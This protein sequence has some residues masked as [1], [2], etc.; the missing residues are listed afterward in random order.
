MLMGIFVLREISLYESPSRRNSET[1]TFSSFFIS[2]PRFL[3][4]GRPIFRASLEVQPGFGRSAE[5][6]S[7]IEQKNK[8]RRRPKSTAGKTMCLCNYEV[9]RAFHVA[10][11]MIPLADRAFLF[12]KAFTEPSVAGPN[13]PSAVSLPALTLPPQAYPFEISRI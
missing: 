2:F 11:L 1:Q 7:V 4:L 10:A 9:S 8:A 6:F 13:S 12:W 3:R 5:L